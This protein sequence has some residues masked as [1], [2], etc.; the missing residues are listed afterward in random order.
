MKDLQSGKIAFCNYTVKWATTIELLLEN[1]LSEL[2]SLSKHSR[3]SEQ[4]K[5]VWHETDF[6]KD[7]GI[8]HAKELLG[9]SSE[10]ITGGGCG[11]P[12]NWQE[13]F[14]IANELH[15]FLIPLTKPEHYTS[16]VFQK[17]AD[18]NSSLRSIRKKLEQAGSQSVAGDEIEHLT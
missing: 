10:A 4:F 8:A 14:T 5:K 9:Y 6:C 17:I 16:D 1:H 12:E 11:D 18:F 2:I 3:D 15:D 13:L 7:C